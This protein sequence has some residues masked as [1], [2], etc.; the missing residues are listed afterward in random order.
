[1]PSVLLGDCL[2]VLGAYSGPPFDLVYLDPPYFLE[3]EFALEQGS[4]VSF[5]GGGSA[6]PD[7]FHGALAQA[8]GA[9][10]LAAY[11]AYLD[12]R[13][14]VIHARMGPRAS[15]FVHIGPR[16]GP[17][18]RLLLDRIFGLENWRA[19]IT[20]QRSHPKNN[21]RSALGNVSDHIYYYTRSSTFTFNVQHTPHDADYLANCFSQRDEAGEYALAPIVQERSRKGYHFTYQG[22]APIHGWRVRRE[23][24]EAYDRAG[25]LHWG[26][27]RPYKKVYLHEAR[28]APLQTIWTDIHNITRTE[29]DR[30]RYP[31]QK[32]LALLERIVALASDPGDLVLDPFCGSGTTLL[33]AARLGRQA[34]GIDVSPEAIGLAENR[35]GGLDGARE[36][37]PSPGGAAWPRASG[38]DGSPP[39]PPCQTAH[40]DATL[41]GRKGGPGRRERA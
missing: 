32:P 4:P 28:G 23:T 11:L 7:A 25:R 6:E 1:M 21:I 2:E 22:H 8:A 33:A 29:R 19:T 10:R 13:L 18:V 34:L 39:P 26:K 20:W 41:P 36:G 16:E 9:P 27:S 5:A 14:R 12:A 40:S 15:V 35:L 17:Y 31:T 37:D 38:P 3:R 24:L 30:R